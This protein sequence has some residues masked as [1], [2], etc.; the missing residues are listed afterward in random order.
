MTDTIPMP[1]FHK[2]PFLRLLLPLIVGIYLGDLLFFRGII[3]SASVMYTVLGAT[4]VLLLL[5]FFPKR[6]SL[7]WVF[8]LSLFLFLLTSGA[9]WTNA[10]LQRTQIDFPAEETVYRVHITEKPQ[11]K[12]RSMLCPVRLINQEPS[13]P[14]V[15]L[16]LNKDSL[17]QQLTT[18]DELLVS[19]RISPPTN[20]GNPDEFDY[21]RYAL[22]KGIS[23]TG[24][25]PSERWKLIAHHPP[26]S[27]L[28]K[29][30]AYRERLLNE[31][32]RLGFEGQTFAVLS[33]LTVGYV[34]ELD[35]ELR[36]SYSVSG[37][38]HILSLSGLHIGFLY[39]LLFFLLKWL[40]PGNNRGAKWLRTGIILLSLW[41]F[42][43]FTGLAAPVVRSVCM[44]SLFALSIPF[45]RKPHTY[46]SL[47]AA[48]FG[49]LLYRPEWLF[50]IGFQLSFCAVL[51]ILGLQPILYRQLPVTH[52]AGKWIWGAMSVSIAAQIGT[53]PLVLLYFS[54][55]STHF[56]LTNLLV[57]P[58]SSGILYVAV[59]LWACMPLPWIQYWIG[60]I[61]REMVEALNS[62]VRWVEHLPYSSLDQV[63]IYPVEIAGFYL[64]LWACIRFLQRHTPRNAMVC[65]VMLG[66]LGITHTVLRVDDYP[67]QGLTFYNVR[68]CPA[69]HCLAADGR[70]WL[71]YADSLPDEP[72]LQRAASRH[73]T[74]LHLLPPQKITGDFQQPGIEMRNHLLSFAGRRVC[75][76]NDNRWRNK[77]ASQMLSIDYLYVCRGYTGRLEKM[78]RLFTIRQV[79]LDASL[80]EYRRKAF[81]AECYRLG[82]GFLSLSEQG[83]I[84]IMR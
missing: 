78:T 40:I 57:I 52:R 23:G 11:L 4:G 79:V 56:L 29:A 28:P 20:N 72:R 35:D 21:A 6:Y 68:G 46:N 60:F 42:A 8:G 74:R 39:A 48:A 75:L 81:E 61:L 58:L 43:F 36:E 38:S 69:V 54:R 16:Y 73:W 26:S 62:F 41:S 33:A 51:A 83:S 50:D 77:V 67:R 71:V 59:L 53:A 80:P 76:L 22:R 63:W 24:Y 2:F 70:S 18:G 84:R 13:P 65:L 15:L 17:S 7:R 49:M 30:L 19:I 31:Y 82:I 55:F 3:P 25:V 32:R 9:L 1:N 27:L 14:T 10:R 34:N 45:R 47:F 66:V 12:E 44:C 37:A 5:A 64:L